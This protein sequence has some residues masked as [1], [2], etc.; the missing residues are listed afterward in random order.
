M[1]DEVYCYAELPDGRDPR[2]MCFQTKSFPDPCMCTARDFPR[3]DRLPTR[4]AELALRVAA[5][6]AFLAV[7]F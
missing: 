2:G 1:Y 7:G 5:D 6:F 3:A 4:L